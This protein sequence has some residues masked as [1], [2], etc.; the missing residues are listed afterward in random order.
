MD[1]KTAHKQ[2]PRKGRVLARTLAEDLSQVQG[3]GLFHTWTRG[4]EPGDFDTD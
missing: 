4:I 1:K 2:Q 3:N